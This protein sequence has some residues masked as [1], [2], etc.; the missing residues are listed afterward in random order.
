MPKNRL[1]EGFTLT[2]LLVVI[3][4]IGILASIVIARV[5]TA[6]E[7]ALIAKA[8]GDIH[9]IRTAIQPLALDTDEWPGHKIIDDVQ[10]GTSGNELWDLTTGE[11]GLVTTDGLYTNWNGP[12]IQEI[13]PDP[14]GNPYFFDT[15]Y[16]IDPTAGEIWAAVIGSFGP[17]GDGQNVYDSDNVILLLKEE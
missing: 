7:L 9:A 14:W 10:S 12:Y 11:V 5:N 6:R 13:P 15:D 16:D 8:Q 2:E 1:R 17:N 3:A 4:I